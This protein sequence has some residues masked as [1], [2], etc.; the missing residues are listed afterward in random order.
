[1]NHAKNRKSSEERIYEFRLLYGNHYTYTN[2]TTAHEQMI[3]I[4]PKHR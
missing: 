3:V 2:I 4:C 1:M